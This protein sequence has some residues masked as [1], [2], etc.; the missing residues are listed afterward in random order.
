MSTILVRND[1][2]GKW[3]VWIGLGDG[4][5]L[6]DD[7]FIVGLGATRDEALAAAVADLEAVVA[8]LQSEPA[9]MAGSRPNHRSE[10]RRDC[11]LNSWLTDG[12]CTCDA[13]GDDPSFPLVR[14]QETLEAPDS[15][16]ADETG[17][18]RIDPHRE[19]GRS[20]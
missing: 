10:H 5:P 6:F 19:E 20:R 15:G 3:Q 12:P 9:G 14:A 17:V 1:P 2:P 4:D 7:G 11:R 18:P 8:Q 16:W 13:Q